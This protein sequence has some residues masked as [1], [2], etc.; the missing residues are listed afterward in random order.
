MMDQ[1][2]CDSYV[3]FCTSSF[4]PRKEDAWVSNLR[5]PYYMTDSLPVGK[6]REEKTKNNKNEKQMKD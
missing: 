3:P 5:A 1:T 2:Q 6:K 4:I